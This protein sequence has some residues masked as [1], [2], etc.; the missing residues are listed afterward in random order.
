LKRLGMISIVLFS[1]LLLVCS[2]SHVD[3]FFES[4]ELERYG[5]REFDGVMI[6]CVS[7][8]LESTF[9]PKKPIVLDDNE[10]KLYSNSLF[11]GTPG[12]IPFE[13]NLIDSY[14]D[15]YGYSLINSLPNATT[16][17]CHLNLIYEKDSTYRLMIIRIE[18]DRD[19]YADE[20]IDVL[21]DVEIESMQQFIRVSTNEDGD[22]AVSCLDDETNTIYTYNI[23]GTL[24][25][26]YEL[27]S[28]IHFLEVWNYCIY[29]NKFCSYTLFDE[30][31]TREYYEFD[32]DV[33][34]S[35]LITKTTVFGKQYFIPVCVGNRVYLF[36]A[37][38]DIKTKRGE[39]LGDILLYECRVDDVVEFFDS[40]AV[41]KDG[42]VFINRVYTASGYP[43]ER[44]EVDLGETYHVL[45]SI[46][47]D[48]YYSATVLKSKNNNILLIYRGFDK[49]VIADL[50]TA[51]LSPSIVLDD[52]FAFGEY[53]GYFIMCDNENM[54]RVNF[55][56]VETYYPN[57]DN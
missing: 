9:R 11:E 49:I 10:I 45:S 42:I 53:M 39:S 5:D 20:G 23:D 47:Y 40:H 21:T 2:C 48:N 16:I 7:R 57:K 27:E 51:D 4:F 1:V 26:K 19:D 15:N 54:Y 50:G 24:K 18:V 52:M 13:G 56:E 12:V 22:Y 17:Y 32:E 44:N 31:K 28:K 25:Y 36:D 37:F 35:G 14:M 6:E 8:G 46:L 29:E 38:Y 43:I 41:T 55:E 30:F 33:E 34:K 3:I